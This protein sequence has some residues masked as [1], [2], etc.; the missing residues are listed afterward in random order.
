[1]AAFS[2]LRTD[3]DL[4]IGGAEL[5]VEQGNGLPD[6]TL[7]IARAGGGNLKYL[8]SV[9]K[10]M[11]PFIGEDGQTQDTRDSREAFAG[12]LAETIVL[13]WSGVLDEDGKTEIP[14]SVEACREALIGAPDLLDRVTQFAIDRENFRQK[15]IEDAK[16]K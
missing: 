6:A 10:H 11:A 14:F 1:M 9:A 2:N 7:K 15:K 16:K 12:A 8:A 5:R 3:R 4:E 13:D